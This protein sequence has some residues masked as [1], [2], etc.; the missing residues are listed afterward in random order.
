[1]MI[2]GV[3]TAIRAIVAV[4]GMDRIGPPY[5]MAKERTIDIKNTFR[6]NLVLV[7]IGL[8]FGDIGR[9]TAVSACSQ[10]L[11]WVLY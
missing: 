3:K 10:D 1:M 9:S 7:F 11:K 2:L 6:I 8:V 5:L 4:E